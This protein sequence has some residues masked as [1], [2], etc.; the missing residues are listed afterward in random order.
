MMLS[1]GVNFNEWL[2]DQLAGDEAAGLRREL[3]EV[4][5][6]VVRFSSNDYLGLAGHP[7]L[8]EAAARVMAEEGVGAGA[9]RL[10][11]GHTRHHRV[12]EEKLAA[13]KQVERVLTF[14]T[15]YAAACG[16][17][18]AL[19]GPGDW[20]VMDRLAHGCLMDGAR[21][22][23]ARV[24]VFA[25]NEPGALEE[26]LQWVRGQDAQS[27]V[28]VVTESVFSM[29]GDVA[30]L[31]EIC[32][33]KD[34]YGAWLMVDEAHATGVFGDGGRG[35]CGEPGV[36]G[37]VEVQMGTLGKALGTLGGFIAGSTA[38]V[39]WLV[40]RARTFMFTTAPPAALAAASAAAVDLVMSAEGRER[41]LKLARHLENFHRILPEATVASP[42]VPLRVGD[43]AE[44]C[45]V[46]AAL[47]ARGFHVPAIRFPTVARGEAR[48]RVSLSAAHRAEDL[49]GLAAVWREV[50]D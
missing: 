45:R 17:I 19:V 48:L 36:A 15:G 13:F 30:P 41:R 31:R 44:A 1:G 14:P 7:A 11:A 39:E 43:E 25:H 49:E 20:V 28:L 37:R 34:R 12:L 38:L 3:A 6:R 47:L 5:P 21:L 50:R 33:I 10:V 16:T 4:P 24:R 40:Q 8:R 29:D 18:P 2:R 46:A 35:L 23:G 27:R 32:E 22:S 26:V 9:A 42:I